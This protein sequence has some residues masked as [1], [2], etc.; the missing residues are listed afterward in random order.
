MFNMSIGCILARAHVKPVPAQTG[1]GAL[2]GSKS[3]PRTR[4]CVC[5]AEALFFFYVWTPSRL[6]M[7][8]FLKLLFFSPSQKGKKAP[9]HRLYNS[10]FPLGQNKTFPK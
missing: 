6:T 1:F 9:F 8:P 3:A 10:S 4:V 2:K 7:C 5:V